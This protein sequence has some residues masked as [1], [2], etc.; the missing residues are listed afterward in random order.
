MTTLNHVVGEKIFYPFNDVKE[1]EYSN[2]ILYCITGMH[3][4]RKL[5]KE[6]EFKFYFLVTWLTWRWKLKKKKK[7]LETGNV[8]KIKLRYKMIGKPIGTSISTYFLNQFP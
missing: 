4:K 1:T 7:K 8:W 6:L 5:K 2:E 3:A